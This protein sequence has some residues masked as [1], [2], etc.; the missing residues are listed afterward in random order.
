ML[1]TELIAKINA[2]KKCIQD[3]EK[4]ENE[5]LDHFDSPENED[6]IELISEMIMGL[7]PDAHGCCLYADSDILDAYDHL[8]LSDA[9]S[10][11]L[12]RAIIDR[13]PNAIEDF[14][15]RPLE[16]KDDEAMLDAINETM[17][18]MPNEELRKFYNNFCS[19]TT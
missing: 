1:K 14:I 18:Q 3:F 12:I 6:S 11:E 19:E 10:E 2:L 8:V 17:A 5:I 13:G 16:F 9:E 7:I 4:I 15:G